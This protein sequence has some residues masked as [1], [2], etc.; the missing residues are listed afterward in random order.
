ILIQPGEAIP[1]VRPCSTRPN[2]PR[3]VMTVRKRVG[4]LPACRLAWRR[5]SPRYLDHIPSSSSSPRN[6]S[7][8]YSSGLDAPVQAH[9]GSL[10]R[11]VSPRLGYP[12]VRAP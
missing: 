9:S 7:P 5:V 1:L 4:P 12:L 2:A 8:V 3:R 11:V 6:S 10:T